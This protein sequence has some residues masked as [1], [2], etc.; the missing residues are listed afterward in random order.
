MAV[1]GMEKSAF[2]VSMVRIPGTRNTLDLFHFA[3][4]GNLDKSVKNLINSDL[5]Y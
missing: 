5:V 3:I 4:I 2:K 1:P